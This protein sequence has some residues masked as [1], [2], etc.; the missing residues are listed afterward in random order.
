MFD[1]APYS[2]E[3]VD[4]DWRDLADQVFPADALSAAPITSR[5]VFIR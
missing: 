1:I 3:T 4:V 5:T 2:Q